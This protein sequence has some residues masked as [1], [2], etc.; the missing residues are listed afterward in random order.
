LGR[1]QRGT[2]RKGSGEER[3][4]TRPVFKIAIDTIS[5]S[6]GSYYLHAVRKLPT[7][8]PHETVI[9]R[10]KMRKRLKLRPAKRF[11]AFGSQPA[12]PWRLLPPVGSVEAVSDS[13]VLAVNASETTVG[14]AFGPSDVGWARGDCHTHGRSPGPG[15]C[16]CPQPTT[17]DRGSPRGSPHASEEVSSNH[18][19]GACVTSEVLNSSAWAYDAN[20]PKTRNR[21]PT[22]LRSSNHPSQSPSLM[23]RILPPLPTPFFAP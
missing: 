12:H 13:C 1:G 7:L 6:A 3:M 9:V 18:H 11:I 8:F 19:P 20:G 17:D 21:S 15:H 16:V 14:S 2:K 10:K 5:H 22:N 4:Q 23:M